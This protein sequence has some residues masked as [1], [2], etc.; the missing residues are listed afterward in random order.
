MTKNLSFKSIALIALVLFGLGLFTSSRA[1]G[2]IITTH[3]P[4]KIRP[5][6][7]FLDNTKKAPDHCCAININGPD[8]LEQTTGKQ[9]IANSHTKLKRTLQSSHKQ[10][11]WNPS[12][13]RH[14][15][16]AFPE[17]TAWNQPG[18]SLYSLRTSLIFYA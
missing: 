7:S 1:A 8:C 9:A 6:R 16:V 14:P 3:A 10:K 15:L 17:K 4:V 13:S 18:R 2:L 11:R 12:K 5:V